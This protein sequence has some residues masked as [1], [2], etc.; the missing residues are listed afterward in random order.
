MYA[1]HLH[2]NSGT[3]NEHLPSKVWVL[4][5]ERQQ[6]QNDTLKDNK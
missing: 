3:K 5:L 1:L 2:L 4:G 6:R